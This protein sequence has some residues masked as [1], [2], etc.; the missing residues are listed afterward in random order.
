MNIGNGLKFGSNER[1]VLFFICALV[2]LLPVLSAYAREDVFDETYNICM[3][4]CIDPCC[5]DKCGYVACT[6][7]AAA[8]QM[9][10]DELTD[11][12]AWNAAMEACQP[13]ISDIQRCG[14]AYGAQNRFDG[15]RGCELLIS[16]VL[17]DHYQSLGKYY[18]TVSIN[19]EVKFQ[20]SATSVFS[21]GRP[22]DSIFSNWRIL[23]IK[24]PDNLLRDGYLYVE[25]H[26]EG[27]G[28]Q[29]WIGIDYME[30]T[31]GGRKFRT[32]IGGVNNYGVADRAA[33]IIYNEETTGWAM[34]LPRFEPLRR[35]WR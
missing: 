2:L 21:H 12:G 35:D 24:V 15:L 6:A 32:E 30:L 5:K 26:H 17:D 3:R 11:Q 10:I 34:E 1:V 23:R 16:G 29:T 19:G 4:Y 8:K 9:G 18:M 31:C 28:P 13:R 20:G 27:S 7:R 25:F 33:G 14:N 22:Y